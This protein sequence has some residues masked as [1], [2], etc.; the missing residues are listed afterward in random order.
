M[1]LNYISSLFSGSLIDRIVSKQLL[2]FTNS[3]LSLESLTLKILGFS[4]SIC[5]L[6]DKL[7]VLLRKSLFEG[8]AIYDVKTI[9][10]NRTGYIFLRLFIRFYI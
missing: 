8:N 4:I 5:Q 7:F 10:Y 9:T 3:R 2:S 6:L 1:T